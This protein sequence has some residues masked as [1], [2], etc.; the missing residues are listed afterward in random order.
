MAL[1]AAL[2]EAAPEASPP[3]RSDPELVVEAEE[4]ACT[5]HMPAKQETYPAETGLPP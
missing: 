2:P 4:G 1:L 3:V 5:D